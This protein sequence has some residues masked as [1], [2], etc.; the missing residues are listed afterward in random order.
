MINDFD[1]SWKMG[2]V[3]SNGISTVKKKHT[4]TQAYK[5][6]CFHSSFKLEIHV[7]D[8][9]ECLNVVIERAFN[10]IDVI[11]VKRTEDV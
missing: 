9:T 1:Q 11:R 5:L 8:Y 6:L 2:K 3:F 7:F 10:I 4:H